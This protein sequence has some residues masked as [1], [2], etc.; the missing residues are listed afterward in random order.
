[1]L[2]RWCLAEQKA[3]LVKKA[4]KALLDEMDIAIEQLKEEEAKEAADG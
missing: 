1:M 4:K 2:G 3:K